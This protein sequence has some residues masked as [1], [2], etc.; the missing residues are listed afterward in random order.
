MTAPPP[1]SVTPPPS[2]HP[3]PGGERVGGK[4]RLLEDREVDLFLGDELEQDRGTL[5]GLGDAALDRGDDL[6]RLGDAL[7]VAAEGLRHVRVVAADVGG[8]VLLGGG[9][10]D[11]KIEGQREEDEKDR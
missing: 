8:A 10:N 3:L 11:K 5:A 1:R 7:P 9:L 2:P 4:G 6:A